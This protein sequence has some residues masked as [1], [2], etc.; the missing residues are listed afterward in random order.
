LSEVER[1]APSVA[2]PPESFRENPDNKKLAKGYYYVGVDKSKLHWI[3]IHCRHPLPSA[4]AVI[5]CRHPLPSALADGQE[6]FQN[7]RL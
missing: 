3:F 1:S 7:K 4:I 6:A 2:I 5:H